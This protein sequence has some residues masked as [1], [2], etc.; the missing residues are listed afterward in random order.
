MNIKHSLNINQ[1]NYMQEVSRQRQ[2][3]TGACVKKKQE[4]ILLTWQ[5]NKNNQ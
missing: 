2:I 3:N 1:D 5:N 4:K